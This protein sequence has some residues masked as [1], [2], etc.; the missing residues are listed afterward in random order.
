MYFNYKK[1]FSVVLQAVADAH[2]KFIFIDVGGYGKQ[3]DGG[4]FHASDLYNAIINEQLNI[5]ELSFLPNTNVKAPYVLVADEAYPLMPFILK[6]YG[7]HNLNIEETVF[8]QRLPRCRKTVE[9]AFGI[10]YS[11]WRLLSKCIETNIWLIEDIVKCICVL[12]N[13]IID[14]EGFELSYH[15]NK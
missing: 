14:K 13:T 9:C 12:H 7:G 2:Y 11:N 1:I 3:S 8:N 6:P 4:L 5:P 10:I 15:L